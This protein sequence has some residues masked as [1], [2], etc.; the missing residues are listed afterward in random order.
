[1]DGVNPYSG[2]ERCQSIEALYECDAKMTLMAMLAKGAKHH[3]DVSL[4]EGMD[5]H[6]IDKC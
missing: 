6:G 4:V 5:T 3:H 2:S 1:M